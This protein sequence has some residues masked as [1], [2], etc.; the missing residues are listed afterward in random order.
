[1]VIDR[2][3]FLRATAA[4]A[5]GALLPR[6]APAAVTAQGQRPR[7]EWG[8]MSGDVTPEGAVIWSRTDRPSRMRVEWAL[9]AQFATATPARSVEVLASS[10]YTGK[11]ALTGL[12]QG[13]EIFYRVGFESLTDGAQAEPLLGR[14][15][16]PDPNG[17]Q[18]L[19]FAWSGDTCGQ[20]YGINP[21]LGGM[22][23]FEAIRAERPDVFLHC[24]DMIYADQPLKPRKGG[25]R[26]RTW[27]NLVT[28]AKE[29]VAE[30]LDE[31]R[32]NF[33]YNLLDTHMRRLCAEVP[34]VVQWDDHETKNNW[35][36][37]RQLDEDKRYRVKSCSLLSARGR[38]AMFEYTPIATRLDAPGRIY[39]ALP[40][41]PLLETFVLDARSYRAPNSRNQQPTYGPE[42]ACFGPEQVAWLCQRL[43]ASTATW[44]LVSCDMPLSLMIGHARYSFEGIGNGAGPPRG[45]EHEV[46]T[47]LGFIKRWRIRNVVFVTADVHYAAA[48]HYSPDR[49]TFTDFDPFWEFVAGPLNAGTFGPNRIDPTFGPKVMYCS[50]EKGQ[51]PGR[52]PLDGHQFYG[53]GKVD[54][55]SRALTV[56]LH[57][58]TGKSLW[59]TTIQPRA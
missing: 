15:R 49:A 5:A 16:T 37:G 18:P 3:H 46:A 25:G 24:G 20:G 43:K 40:F 42:S 36:P 55:D 57:D 56:S 1:M 14:L 32:G 33:R 13:R 44:K 30:T 45:R 28:P 35:W 50:E 26:G 48:H 52:S 29:K 51:K 58:L 47:L 2:R 9:D 6:R 23:I 31:F 10:D 8:V 39:R 59:D 54:P 41:G 38:R 17:N 27:E 7:A 11:V 22:R 12:P 19:T 53:V 34:W 4:V 21:R